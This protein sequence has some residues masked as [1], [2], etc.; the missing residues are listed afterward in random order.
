MEK[1]LAVES[2]AMLEKF[3]SKDF[4]RVYF[5]P[6]TC[7]RKIPSAADAKKAMAFCK[8]HG[9]KFSLLAPF[10]TDSGIARLKK[11]FP[12]LSAEDEVIANDFSVLLEAK[13]C[14]ASLIAG[15]LLNRQSRDPRIASLK[16]TVPEEMLEHFSLS[17]AALPEFRKL[18]SSFSVKRFELDNLPQGIGTSLSGTGFS[19]SLYYP[20]VFVSATR[21]CLSA[22]AGKIAE[23][24]KVGIF[25]CGK[26]CSQYS[27]KLRNQAFPAGLF[28]SGNALFF[29]NN[30]LPLEA[31]LKQKGIDRIVENRSLI[32]L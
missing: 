10:C 1:A 30:S 25:P 23:S 21:L 11:I 26:E 2:I 14:N 12:L 29:E 28:L 18:L 9:V 17:Q 7:E 20:F 19:A 3:F 13:N 8:N 27:F 24:K 15:R 6:E 22:N 5:G 4:A 32:Q 31:V 16:G